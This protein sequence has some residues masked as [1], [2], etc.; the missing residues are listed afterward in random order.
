MSAWTT[1]KVY[2]DLQEELEV[3]VGLGSSEGIGDTCRLPI[4]STH[5]ERE[6]IDTISGSFG[7]I[8]SPSR[9]SIR[10]CLMVN[11]TRP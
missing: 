6:S 10:V 4:I 9:G 8:I 3:T 1:C 7:N 2:E 5:V 11:S